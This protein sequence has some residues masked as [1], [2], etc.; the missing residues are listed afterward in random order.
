[1]LRAAWLA[2]KIET[3]LADVHAILRTTMLDGTV[4]IPCCRLTYR[5]CDS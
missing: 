2:G 1:M 5:R 4:R 3:P